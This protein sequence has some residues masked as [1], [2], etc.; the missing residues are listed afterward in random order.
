MQG[1]WLG[2]KAEKGIEGRYWI[3]PKSRLLCLKIPQRLVYVA[4]LPI[5][6]RRTSTGN[7]KGEG[8]C[9]AYLEGD[10]A[11]SVKERNFGGLN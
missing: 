5:S 9:A 7:G 1:L 8:D 11:D 3:D 6:R 2:H 10:D 4:M